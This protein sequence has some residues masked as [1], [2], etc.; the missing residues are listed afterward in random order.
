M[1]WAWASRRRG[2]LR[3]ALMA[4]GIAATLVA[5]VSQAFA[6]P[7]LGSNAEQAPLLPS[8]FF[9][10]MPQLNGPQIGISADQL[11]YDANRR[12]V[13][14]TGA[15]EID[16]QGYTITGQH[17]VFEQAAK[18]AHF[19]G[20]VRVKAPDDTIY[21]ATDLRLSQPMRQA[22]MRQL[23][24][25]TPE[26]GLVLAGDADF[27]KGDRTILDNASYSPC[28]QC[29]DAKGH[30]IGWSVKAAR[31]LYDEKALNVT[32]DQPTLYLLGVPMAWV[33]WLRIPD[34][35]KRLSHFEMPSVDYSRGT[36]A[37]LTVPY[38]IAAGPDDDYI[39]APTLMSRQGLLMAG[40]WD[41]RFPAG[42][43]SVKAYAVDQLDP[44][45]FS[46]QVGDRQWRGALQS[47]GEFVPAATWVVGWS[48]TM[49]SDANFFSDYRIS[50]AKS[51][52]NEAYATHLGRN[53]YFDARVQQFNLLG[54]YTQAD[55]DKQGLAIPNIRYRNVLYL[56]Q[57]LGEVDVMG[58]LLGVSRSSTDE[59]GVT[60]GVRYNFG[61]EETKAHATVETDWQKQYIAGGMALTPFLGIRGDAAYA[62]YYDPT[63]T[64][65]P[66]PA[67][68]N[69]ADL[70]HL[71]PI[72]AIDA[73]YPMV[74]RA[75][76]TTHVLEPIIQ[77]VYRGS[78]TTDLGITNDDAQSFVLE[79]SNLF[80]YNRFA[81]NDRQETGLRA[82]VGGHYQID[83]DNGGYVD[84]LGGE[85]FQLAGP[86]AF[87][88]TDLTQ[89]GTGS[90]MDAANS[91]V[92][93]GAQGS[94]I[95]GLTAGGK[96][97]LDPDGGRI[98]RAG[99]GAN[100]NGPGYSLGGGY[101]YIAANPARGTLLPQQEVSASATIPLPFVDYWSVQ[102][103][104]AWDVT[105]NTWLA[106]GAG[107]FYD[108]GYL[109]Y[110]AAVYATG[111]TNTTPNDLR[112]TGTLFLKGLGGPHGLGG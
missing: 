99:I 66:T 57:Q 43:T 83:F 1:F 40:E 111:P 87:A 33:P 44:G 51:S 68:H 76:F 92:V 88:E 21:T 38:F 109:N 84:L 12:E 10:N 75:G 71:T 86:N 60:N 42:A 47:T 32:L 45:A 62:D 48:Y 28:G 97:Q 95:S 2:S 63:L 77:L 9:D 36:G 15:V 29:I 11:V 37:M 59:R 81:D 16:Y 18:T 104:G 100:Y 73:R 85:S 22:L 55:Q 107:A 7:A 110:G 20:N 39:V 91:Y 80:S 14:A 67:T 3:A 41:H 103:S 96:L 52:V 94:L 82:N 35:T 65:V 102:A 79:D 93:L 53:D 23:T 112:F 58:R 31:M 6:S 25:T 56:P 17:L 72:A 101:V 90:G 70:F 64:A 26:G 27:R 89:V 19:I 106:A 50:N 61:D 34:P 69:Q 108:D 5:G 54:N 24:I 98:T 49:F 13:T 74:A 105:N 78:D 46:G 4:A 8:G 30:R